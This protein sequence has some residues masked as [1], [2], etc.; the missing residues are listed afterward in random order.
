MKLK[1]QIQLLFSAGLLLLSPIVSAQ[2][3]SGVLYCCLNNEQQKV[4]SD[5]RSDCWGKETQAINQH[6]LIVDEIPPPL[7]RT[8]K[9]ALLL[10]KRELEEI[11]K[12]RLDEERRFQELLNVFGSPD[13]IDR[14]IERQEKESDANIKITESRLQTARDNVKTCEDK[15]ARKEKSGDCNDQL[16]ETYKKTVVE[17]E[18]EIVSRKQQ[19]EE[20]KQRLLTSKK[21]IE[22]YQKKL[23]EQGYLNPQ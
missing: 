5:K 8:E 14:E 1:S 11:E 23:I 3:T 20:S 12:Q 16:L 21:E 19:T 6:G 10:K 7:T 2:I 13:A 4:C 22:D 18:A 9:A 15:L 17:I